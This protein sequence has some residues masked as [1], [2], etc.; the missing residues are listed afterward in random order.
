MRD[1][2]IS[3]IYEMYWQELYNDQNAR[4]LRLW[5]DENFPLPINLKPRSI[6][7]TFSPRKSL[8]VLEWYAAKMNKG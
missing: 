8:E 1:E 7:T 4:L 2:Q 3:K 5:N 6:Q